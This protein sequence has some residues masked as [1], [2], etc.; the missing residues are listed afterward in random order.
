MFNGERQ[1]AKSK[2][3]RTVVMKRSLT[4]IKSY[5]YTFDP[6]MSSLK[7]IE[8]VG[9]DA[10]FGYH[11]SNGRSGGTIVMVEVGA[12]ICIC[13]GQGDMG[14]SKIACHTQQQLFYVI[15]THHVQLRRTW[16]HD[17]LPPWNISARCRPTGPIANFSI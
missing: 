16:G 17:L 6:S 14:G 10:T 8:A 3:V 11:G 15:K 4:G 9:T 1:Q 7:Y 2:D 13:R 12:P 5:H